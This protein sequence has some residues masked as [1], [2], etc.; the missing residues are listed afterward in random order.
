MHTAVN[1]NT[2]T[3]I[4][5]DSLYN[6]LIC[7]DARVTCS[8]R[9]YVKRDKTMY[10]YRTLKR[11]RVSIVGVGI[12]QVLHIVSVFSCLSYP[13][14]N[15]HAPY[16]HLWPVPLY[17]IFSTLSHKWHDFR[18]KVTECKMCVLIFCTNLAETFLILRWIERD[19]IE[20]VYWSS[21][22]V[23]V[24]CPILMKIEFS[25]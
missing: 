4:V 20:N 18:I 7:A 16:C 10:V 6:A 23:L 15:A 12:L 21:C 8:K 13:A 1:S 25:W 11:F 17:N 19:M 3:A 9:S 2:S 14:F 24:F 5:T 22:K